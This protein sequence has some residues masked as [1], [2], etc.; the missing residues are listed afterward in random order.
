VGSFYPHSG[1][2]RCPR[3]CSRPYKSVKPTEG[4]YK[5]SGGDGLFL[6]VIRGTLRCWKYRIDGKEDLFTIGT[7]T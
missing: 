4:A 6:L 5:L 7:L 3:T 1:D 2:G